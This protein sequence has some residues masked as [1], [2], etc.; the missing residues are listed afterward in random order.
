VE[1]TAEQV[2]ARL[3]RYAE[4]LKQ[5]PGRAATLPRSAAQPAPAQIVVY[6]SPSGRDNVLPRTAPRSET[7]P[8]PIAR[9]TASQAVGLVGCIISVV[10]FTLLDRPIAIVGVAILAGVGGALA[11]RRVPMSAAWTAGIAIGTV[12]ALI[13]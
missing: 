2:L 13:S 8:R 1:E 12:L 6:K 9:A 10:M 4:S 11:L 3:S 5:S 7:H